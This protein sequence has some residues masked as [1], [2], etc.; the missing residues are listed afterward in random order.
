[1]LQLKPFLLVQL[2][3]SVLGEVSTLTCVFRPSAT[4]SH[5]LEPP[6]RRGLSVLEPQQPLLRRRGARDPRAEQA[7]GLVLAVGSDSVRCTLAHRDDM[8]LE[9]GCVLIVFMFLSTSK[10]T[11]RKAG[12]GTGVL[13]VYLLFRITSLI[14]RQSAR[15]PCRV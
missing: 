7:H 15:Q 2:L 13:W 3:C 8:H 1:M 14:T 10:S 6:D 4:G 12:L 11:C 9:S 5:Q